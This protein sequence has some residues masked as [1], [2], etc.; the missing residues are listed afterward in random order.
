MFYYDKNQQLRKNTF[1]QATIGRKKMRLRGFEF[2]DTYKEAGLT[3]PKRSTGKSAGY[4]FVCAE[5]TLLPANQGIVLVPTG[6]KAYMLDQEYLELVN[7]SSNPL[8]RNLFVTNGVGVI[9]ADYYNNPD[10]EGHIF[11]QMCN[12]GK[13]DLLLKKGE[14]IG[15]GIFKSYLTI[16]N[17]EAQ[18]TRDGGFGSTG[19]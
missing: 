4:D 3:L 11:F 6:V 5:D 12:L 14:K 19:V 2:V 16:D 17:D 15:Q 13:E 7:R 8:K 1:Y 9:D 10:N 18:G